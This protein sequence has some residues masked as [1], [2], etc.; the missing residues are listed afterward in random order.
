M[1]SERA[2]WATSRSSSSIAENFWFQPTEQVKA[3]LALL[4]KGRLAHEI[5]IFHDVGI[6]SFPMLWKR[7][8]CVT[9]SHAE[10]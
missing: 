1:S 8:T 7:Q 4:T 5:W 9:K 2:T 10:T 3:F 6:V